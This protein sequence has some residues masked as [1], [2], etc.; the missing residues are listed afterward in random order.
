[1]YA[2]LKFAS[3]QA[4]FDDYDYFKKKYP[5]H[6]SKV[7]EEPNGTILGNNMLNV[8]GKDMRKAVGKEKVIS[9]RTNTEQ[10]RVVCE[11]H[12]IVAGKSQ[13]AKRARDILECCGIGINDARNGIW[14]PTSQKSIF[15]GWLH[16]RHKTSYDE[17]VLRLLEEMH[18]QHGCSEKHCMEV[19]NYVK[20]A[21]LKGDKN[22]QLIDKPNNT[23]INALY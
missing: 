16:G 2:R 5:K 22:F 15:K 20:S 7:G 18:N 3:K 23:V 4:I 11:A 12:H 19:L 13:A 8:G 17:E 1:M 9:R 14:L 10:S 21:L 6:A